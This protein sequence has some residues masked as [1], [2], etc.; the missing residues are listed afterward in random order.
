MP[1]SDLSSLATKSQRY[2]RVEHRHGSGISF[3]RPISKLDCEPRAAPGGAA[4][5]HTID[6]DPIGSRKQDE[7]RDGV[8]AQT[9]GVSRPKSGEAQPVNDES[10]E[11]RE[12]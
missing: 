8:H 4:E 7:T 9:G 11:S 2:V 5:P 1:Q 3:T 12:A 10:G 6:T